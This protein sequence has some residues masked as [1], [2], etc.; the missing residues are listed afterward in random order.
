[1]PG[2]VHLHNHSHYSLLDGLSKIKPMIKKA[3]GYGMPAIAL[4]DHGTMYGSLNF[5]KECIKAGIKPIIGLEAYVAVR[6]RFDKEPRIDSKRYHLTLLA[7]NYDG[8]QNLIALTTKAHLEGYYYKPRVDKELLRAHAGGLICL[9]GCLGGE[10]ARALWA[11]DAEW[12]DRVVAEH[13][14]IFGRDNYFIE[15]MHHP[16]IER[17]LEIKQALID[18]ARK[19]NL[20]L[21]ATQDAHYLEP[22]D[23]EA[24][25]TLVAIQT[26]TDLEGQG[27][28]NRDEDFS[29]IS[30][31]RAAELF[32]DTPDALENT[33]RIAERCSL[34]LELGKWF[35][36]AV[37]IPE[38]STPETELRRL[39]AEG[40]ARY[41]AKHPDRAD[42]A[43]ER[44]EFEAAII[45]DKGY[46]PYFLTVGEILRY[47]AEH[48]IFTN[49]RGS[50]AGSLVSY[51]IGITTVDPLYFNLPF[52]RFLNPFRPSPPDVD[53]DFAD[54]RR[55]EVLDHV[56]Q[57]YGE[58]K[59]AQIGTFGSML[60]RGSVRDVARALGY[61]YAV[62]DRLSRW[63]PM[64]TQGFPM[65]IKRALEIVPELREA[66][67][68]ETDTKRIIDLAR[69][70]EGGARHISVHAAGVVIAPTPLTDFVPL[71]FDPQGGKI[72]TQYDMRDVEDAG[73]LKFD[74]LG[75]RNLS[76][77]ED[78][79]KIVAR[80]RGQK[81]DINDIPLDDPITFELLARGDTIG[82]FQLN[83]SGMTK[84]LKK[85]KPTN[86]HD[87][88]VMVALYRPG[89]MA[90][91][92]DYIERKH[93]R[94]PITY[95][96]PKMEKFLNTSLGLLVYQDDLLFT[97]IELAGYDWGT[98]DKFRK[99]V[100]KKIPEEMAKQHVLF[101]EGCQTTSGMTAREAE[102]IWKLFEPFQGYGFNKAHAASYGKVAY[103]T[104][105]MKANFP[106]EYMTA[107]LSA[108]AGDVDTVGQMI[109]ECK[110]MGIPVLPPDVNE[111]FGNFTTIKGPTEAED[112]I[113]F[114]L[115]SIKNL[116]TEIAKAIV[117]ERQASGPFTSIANFLERV[118]HR[119]LNKKSLEALVKAGTFDSLGEERGALLGN[120][121]E[122]LAYHQESKQSER[123]QIS[124]FGLMEDQSTIPVLR[125]R[126]TEP[127]SADE[128][129]AW[130]KDLLGLY[131][132]GHPLEKYREKF[133]KA[134]H[135]IR[136]IKK[137]TDGSLA[138]AG[139][140]IEDVRVINTKKGDRMAFIR[141]ADLEDKIEVV[142]FSRV[143]EQFKHLLEPERMIAL[144]GRL[145]FRNDEP[146]IVVETLKE[147]G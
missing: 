14:D 81:I 32:A 20:P 62:G 31:E 36:P 19:H 12:A 96:H 126:P 26:R 17:Q 65:T 42:T 74:F 141:I 53:M 109:A 38:G 110:R 37:A 7:T 138:I 30:P 13:V 9:S 80:T 124:I 18:L 55:D 113:R 82:L 104:A 49:T 2:F 63:I 52:E 115:Y 35:F 28:A 116:G 6:S 23:A 145:S 130:E 59:V 3:Q 108:E 142:V 103:Q 98:V 44:A 132:S 91:I 144:R 86:I 27:L 140:I 100:G 118:Q 72:I 102:R 137:L 40:L 122:L 88:N 76:I 85:L 71:Q 127:S 117:D 111:S 78:S 121:D 93:G 57:K 33:V 10:L 45:C 43:R 25:A 101:V 68:K 48:D 47:A 15:I 61:P 46:A 41:S 75:I 125:L 29:F 94:Q 92:D 69:K 5:Y 84:A 89:P 107:V 134:E 87:I 64:G 147:L 105:Y 90:T 22:E 34:E 79:I 60:A 133:E 95:Y 106:A 56:R 119:N 97:A 146:S 50:A 39:V 8:Y 11:R 120:L 129:L 143:F 4:T 70:I 123:N 24:H 66:Y 77:L 135:T 73:L 114:G 1:M 58:D 67:E 128:R 21:V 99:A 112:T 16:K 131:I 54:K 139:G 51:L 136:S 83:G